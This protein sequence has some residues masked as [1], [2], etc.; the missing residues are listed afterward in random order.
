MSRICCSEKL[1][2]FCQVMERKSVVSFGPLLPHLP[3]KPPEPKRLTRSYVRFPLIRKCSLIEQNGIYSDDIMMPKY[4]VK[5][6]ELIFHMMLIT[7][8]GLN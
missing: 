6:Y 4:Q 5:T 2:L 8:S 7:P 3:S 1:F